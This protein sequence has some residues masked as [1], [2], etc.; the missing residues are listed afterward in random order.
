MRLLGPEVTVPVRTVL[1]AENTGTIR[2]RLLGPE[3]RTARLST[4]P[5]GALCGACA[6]GCRDR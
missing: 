2:M 3:V 5:V 6:M 4:G 1:L